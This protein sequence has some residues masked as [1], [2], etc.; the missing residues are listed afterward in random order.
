MRD[1]AVIDNE[2]MLKR[3]CGDQVMISRGEVVMV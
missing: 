2:V 3:R 1:D